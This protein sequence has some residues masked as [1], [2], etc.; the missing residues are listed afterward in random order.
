MAMGNGPG[1]GMD[2]DPTST[3]DTE[4]AASIGRPAHPRRPWITVYESD[5]MGHSHLQWESCRL[6]AGLLIDHFALQ[7][8]LYRVGGEL[9]FLV[10]EHDPRK[11]VVPDLYIL[12]GEPQA[13]PK[14]PSWKPWERRGK[15]PSLAIEVVSDAYAKDYD[16]DEGLRR[17]EQMGVP[18]V[19]RYDPDAPQHQRTKYPRKLLTHLVRSAA[20][21]LEEQ[22]D[23]AELG[24]RVFIPRYQ[25]WLVH[26]APYYLR[27]GF[28][29][30]DNLT[31]QLTA[32]ERARIAEEQAKVQAGRAEAAE[33]QARVAEEQ[34]RALTAELARLKGDG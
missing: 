17:Y 33:E 32:S 24:D 18:E 20:G 30:A 13:G 12:E 6:L 23:P 27:L 9:Q 3:T 28:G 34:V 1:Y 10:D 19:V 7:P 29:P 25:C 8:R 26:Q 22:T 15:V 4:P 16:P 31:L 14:V 21:K 2:M 11:S 5:K